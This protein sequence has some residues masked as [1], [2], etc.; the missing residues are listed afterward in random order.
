MTMNN[1]VLGYRI[2]GFYDTWAS[3]GGDILITRIC[4]NV[5]LCDDSIEMHSFASKRLM[6][7]KHGVIA[8]VSFFVLGMV[9]L[10]IGCSNLYNTTTFF[11]IR[12]DDVLIYI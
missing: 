3:G 1:L 10:F 5:V 8:T 2:E 6:V 12:E 7:S 11:L 4:H 9:S